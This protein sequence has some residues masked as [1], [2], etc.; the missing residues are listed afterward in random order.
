MEQN[1]RNLDVSEKKLKEL[2]EIIADLRSE[3]ALLIQEQ[4]RLI[5]NQFTRPRERELEREVA[6]LHATV[7][8]LESKIGNDT[9]D[10]D[11]LLN[12]VKALTEELEMWKAEHSRLQGQH[13][14]LQGQREDLERKIQMSS[15]RPVVTKE[16]EEALSLLRLRKEMGLSVGPEMRLEAESLHKSKKL[17]DDMR[18]AHAELCQELD[19]T[20]EILKLQ[21]QINKDYKDELQ[22]LGRKV[23]SMKNEYELRLE[24]DARLL[25]VRA[26]KIASL[27]AQLRS[28]A[29]GTTVD[30]STQENSPEDGVDLSAGQN[31]IELGIG[32]A[33]L[34]VDC[35]NYLRS[36]S[37]ETP[38]E[39]PNVVTFV[40][41]DF[42]DFGTQVS[43][44]GMGLKTVFAQT[45]QFRVAIDDFFL[46]YIQ[47]KAVCVQ[48]Y[49]SIGTESFVIAT[50]N[51]TLKD[52]LDTSK[53]GTLHYCADLISADDGRTV[54]GK[55]EYTLRAGIPMAQ[56]I[57]AHK[58]R[59]VAL[60]LVTD[61][62][63][64]VATPLF[65][66]TKKI[67]DLQVE[68]RQ[69]TGLRKSGAIRSPCAFIACKF[70]NYAE[71][72]TQTIRNSANPSFGYVTK[73]NV[74]MTQDLDRYL[75]TGALLLAVIEDSEQSEHV[76]GSVSV[77]LLN[78]ALNDEVVGTFQLRWTCRILL[79]CRQVPWS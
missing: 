4:S 61:T 53:N 38:E 71:V 13:T 40:A 39:A 49:R 16:M 48:I 42:F 26:N 65:G 54:F 64:S 18:V 35:F 20:R 28:I 75:R 9:G 25:D 63:P 5:S 68:I 32:S 15:D 23:V 51:V 14:V 31:L 36:L 3:K 52:L 59:V 27:E 56:A 2:Q 77:P 1:K 7:T 34:N 10:R 8:Q 70:Y 46:H 24:E 30:S 72:V 45:F 67:N 55:F 12:K 76:Y 33:A 57:R 62:E 73:L 74:S 19:K 43:P 11:H 78:L 50:C 44:I 47:S 58:E 37:A 22:H 60:N 41:F 29:R 21:E 17:L 6:S 79:E 66:S 69:C